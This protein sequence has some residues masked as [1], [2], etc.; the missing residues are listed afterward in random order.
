MPARTFR[1]PSPRDHQSVFSPTRV[2][3]YMYAC[4]RVCACVCVCVSPLRVRRGF[5]L[6]GW[7]WARPAGRGRQAKGPV[8]RR[9][10]EGGRARYLHVWIWMDDLDWI[11][12]CAGVV[13]LLW[14][15][16]AACLDGSMQQPCAVEWKGRLMLLRCHWTCACIPEY[17][18]PETRTHIRIYVRGGRELMLQS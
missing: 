11:R 4:V 14:V 17:T 2:C 8:R 12:V 6:A 16:C 5:G 3:V 18:Q 9:H 15:H 1:P 13:C 7:F 10:V